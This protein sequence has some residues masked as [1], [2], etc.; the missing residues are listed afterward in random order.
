MKL[1]IT[2]CH[3]IYIMRNHRHILRLFS[4][5]Y[6]RREYFGSILGYFHPVMN[7]TFGAMLCRL[8]ISGRLKYTVV[9]TLFVVALK[10]WNN[11]YHIM[12]SCLETFID[13]FNWMF[14]F[15]FAIINDNW[16]LYFQLLNYKTFYLIK[17]FYLFTS[18]IVFIDNRNNLSDRRS[19][20][21]DLLLSMERAVSDGEAHPSNLSRD[22]LANRSHR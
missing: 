20:E 1:K 12:C 22:N 14:L 11:L 2:L 17:S 10:V 6:F 21:R 16:R 5:S 4:V 18:A 19:N 3:I 8:I 15:I 13:M 9:K 7:T